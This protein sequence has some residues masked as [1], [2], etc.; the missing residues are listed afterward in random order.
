VSDTITLSTT[1]ADA[2]APTGSISINSGAASTTSTSVTLTLSATDAV[3][4]TG[5]YVSETSTTPTATASGWTSVTSTTSYSN[6]SVSF[7]LSSGD[8]TKTVYAWF[9]DA[10]GNVSSSVSD[11]IT[12]S[13][14]TT[15]GS[16]LM[17]GSIQG[18][19]LNLTSTN[20]AVT[21]FAG[22]AG[23][24]GSTDGTGTSARFYAPFGTTTDGT[25]LFVSDLYNH[26]IRKIV[27]STGVVT[28][29][30]GTAGSIGSTD[31]TGTSARFYYPNGIT[32]DGTN[33]FVADSFNHTIR[34]IVIS[35]GVV[36]TIAGTAGSVGSTDGTGTSA[37]FYTPQGITTDGTNL[38]VVDKGN[39]TI[40]KIV[41]ST[42]VVTTIAGTAGSSGSTDGTGTSARFYYPNGI[43]TDGTNL[44][45][46][47]T[48]NHTIR[49]I[50]IST[51]VV[52]TI[53][54]TAGT[55]GSTDGTG[56]SA[57]FILP[58]DITTDGTNLFVADSNNS[59]IRKIVISTGV[60]TTIAG[61]AGSS[62]QGSTDG[63]GTSARFYGPVGITTDGTNLFVA[64]SGNSTIRK[65]HGQ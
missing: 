44:F 29:I 36:T 11:T 54:G 46:A 47:D 21:T 56:T 14:T 42:G 7:T 32:T 53:A 64:D 25:N 3:G 39:H 24:S 22:S 41:I 5:Y 65:I 62:G 6:S 61:T 13:T 51:G 50:V 38:F 57:R 17:G 20:A 19:S 33:L 40:R 8:G 45:V 12:L 59:T 15:G 23:S 2:T 43:N 1:V 63:T 9:K 27:I 28:T 4:V 49:K 35:T 16:T 26:T 31:G 18:T 10:A 30:A 34:K 52:T 58:N 60:V 55:Y 48:S 37:R